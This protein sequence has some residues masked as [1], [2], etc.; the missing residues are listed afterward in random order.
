MR[1]LF[2]LVLF[3]FGI[4]CVVSGCATTPEI[5]GDFTAS[6]VREIKALIDHRSDIRKPILRIAGDDGRARVETGH[7][8]KEGDISQSFTVAKRQGR[9][10]IT[11]SID[12]EQIT[13]MGTPYGSGR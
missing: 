3:G 1:R 7:D 9:W 12:E 2:F 8:G 6:D 10:R 4:V 13:G 5:S 11:S